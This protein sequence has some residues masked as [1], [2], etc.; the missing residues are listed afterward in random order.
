MAP[1][2]VP[3]MVTVTLRLPD[4]GD[5]LMILGFAGAVM[6]VKLVALVPVPPGVVTTI[7]PLVAPEGTVAVICVALTTLK[8]AAVVPLKATAVA[9]VKPVPVKVTEVPTEP[10]VGVKLVTVVATGGGAFAVWCGLPLAV[11]GNVL[12]L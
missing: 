8:I 11:V 10:E 9:P 6:T 7:V 12:T 3:V 1:K 4:V 2:A 5:S